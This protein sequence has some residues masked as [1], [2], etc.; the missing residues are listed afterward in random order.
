MW[1]RRTFYRVPLFALPRS[2]VA[3]ARLLWVFTA[4]D[5]PTRHKARPRFWS[6]SMADIVPLCPSFWSFVFYL[7]RSLRHPTLPRSAEARPRSSLAR[8][9]FP[10][11]PPSSAHKERAANPALPLIK[12][13]QS[14]KPFHLHG[15]GTGQSEVSE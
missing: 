12:L 10:S 4:A 3:G 7:Q 9:H 14:E 1:H 11:Q 8:L 5:R 6:S 13:H 2:G 15:D